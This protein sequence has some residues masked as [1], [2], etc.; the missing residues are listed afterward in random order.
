MKVLGKTRWETPELVKEYENFIS[1][2]FN[3]RLYCAQAKHDLRY[4]WFFG[5]H[6]DMVPGGVRFMLCTT[7]YWGEEPVFEDGDFL[8][9]WLT[10]RTETKEPDFDRL[11]SIM[12]FYLHAYNQCLNWLRRAYPEKEKA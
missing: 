4:R 5:F 9:W 6:K 10:V 8:L 1:D 3:L 12:K 2:K 7:P 11:N